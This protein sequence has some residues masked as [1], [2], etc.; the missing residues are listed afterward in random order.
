ME[1]EY[2][3]IQG[4]WSDEGNINADPCFARLGYWD[5]GIWTN[6]DY[7]LKSCVGRWD[8]LA[9][10]WLADEE[11]SPCIDAASTD[12]DW[13]REVWPHGGR[14][15]MGAYGGTSEASMSCI[16]SL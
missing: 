12:A 8:P 14:I 4:G 13:T 2:S 5:N 6:G 9:G 16:G 3:D 7:H 10:D 15:N 11:H 1:I